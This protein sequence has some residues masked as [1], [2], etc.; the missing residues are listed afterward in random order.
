MQ[1]TSCS[2]VVMRSGSLPDCEAC[3]GCAAGEIDQN[4]VSAIEEVQLHLVFEDAD[5][6]A[7]FE[8][9]SE[10]DDPRTCVTFMSVS[11]WFKLIRARWKWVR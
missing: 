9:C 3:N 4:S 11:L 6:V 10:L 5:A 7:A 2:S 8:T 1:G